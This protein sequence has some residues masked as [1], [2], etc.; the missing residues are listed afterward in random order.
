[1]AGMLRNRR[2]AQSLSDQ[3]LEKGAAAARLRDRLGW[4]TAH[5]RR[6]VPPQPQDV[7]ST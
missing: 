6:P 4:R 7:L 2:L 5:H 3:S 1:M